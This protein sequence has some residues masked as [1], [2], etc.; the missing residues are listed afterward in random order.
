VI[1]F[2]LDP[3]QPIEPVDH[4]TVLAGLD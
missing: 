2:E 3:T 1:P 4:K